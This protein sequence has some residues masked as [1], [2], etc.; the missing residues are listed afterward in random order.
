MSAA[1]LAGAVGVAASFARLAFDAIVQRDAP[2]ANRG[3]AF[4]QFETRFQIA[5]VMAAFVPVLIPIPRTVGF[6]IVTLLAVFALVSYVVGWRARSAPASPCRRALPRPACGP[7]CKARRRSREQRQS[8]RARRARRSAP[9]PRPSDAQ[10]EGLSRRL[11]D[12]EAGQPEAGRVHLGRGG[13]GAGRGPQPGQ[14][15][16]R[17]RAR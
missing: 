13:Q 1:L 4:A 10:R 2:D 16:P 12:L 14:A 15:R 6:L 8:D 11:V 17:P 3:R 5:W 9:I 7:R